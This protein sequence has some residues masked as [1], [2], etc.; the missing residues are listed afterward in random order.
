MNSSSPPRRS[1]SKVGRDHPSTQSPS[2]SGA[3]SR[4]GGVSG[5]GLSLPATETSGLSPP[6]DC[7]R[8]CRFPPT[9]WQAA[10]SGA[11][12]NTPPARTALRMRPRT[13]ISCGRVRCSSTALANTPSYGSRA[14]RCE[15]PTGV[16]S[17][18]QV[19]ARCPRS[20]TPAQRVGCRWVRCVAFLGGSHRDRSH[21]L[22]LDHHLV[23]PC[24][25]EAVRPPA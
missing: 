5:M 18:I 12:A 14:Q 17:E 13:S 8:Q 4:Q 19:R 11:P 25:L 7:R 15:H 24:P 22:S 16:P 9:R 23:D 1:R 6:G 10:A 20:R 2:S 3:A 21:Q